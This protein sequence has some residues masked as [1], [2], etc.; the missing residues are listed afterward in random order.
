MSE[1][2]GTIILDEN[3]I[4]LKYN[5]GYKQIFEK[6]KPSGEDGKEWI[7]WNEERYYLKEK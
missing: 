3:K 4:T 5:E 6:G 2:L 7:T 1:T